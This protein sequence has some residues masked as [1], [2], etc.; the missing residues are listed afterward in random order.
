MDNSFTLGSTERADNVK[1][2]Q[3]CKCLL[4]CSGLASPAFDYVY[5]PRTN[6]FKRLPQPENSHDDSHF[7]IT[8]VLRMAFD[9][10]KSLDNKVVQVVAG[11]DS[12]H[13]IQV[14]SSETGNCSM[15]RDQLIYYKFAHFASAIY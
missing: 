8:V 3:S 7:H 11:P 15:C 12:D 2:L 9:H 4:L 13:E 1:I 6:L 14:Y 10:R 5:N